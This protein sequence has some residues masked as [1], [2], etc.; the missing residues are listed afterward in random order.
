MCRECHKEELTTIVFGNEDDDD[1][2]FVYL[3]DCKHT[4]EATAMDQWV[5]RS[6]CPDAESGS[7]A[8]KLP[9]CPKCKTPI[10]KTLR[11]S[12]E[13]NGVMAD[14]RARGEAGDCV[15]VAVWLFVC[16]GIPWC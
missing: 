11:Y 2:R 16:F 15:C 8:V 6:R 9:E 7:V 1:A 3:V 12:K 14:V 4:I 13:V 10:R 5:A